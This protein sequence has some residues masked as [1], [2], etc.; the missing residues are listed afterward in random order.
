[1]GDVRNTYKSSLGNIERKRPARDLV[2]DGRINTETDRKDVG[3]EGVDS[4][5]LAQ[6]VVQWRAPV[7]IL[8]NHRVS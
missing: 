1:M 5:H 4:I 6:D 7:N 2:V 3:C 8:M